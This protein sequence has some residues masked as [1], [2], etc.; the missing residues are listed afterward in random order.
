LA[1]EKDRGLGHFHHTEYN[2]GVSYALMGKDVA[3]IDWLRKTADH[4]FSCPVIQINP[5]FQTLLKKSK[6]E[7]EYYRTQLFA[8]Q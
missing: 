2:I 8:T 7:M 3:A 5:D 4:G 6:N 1:I